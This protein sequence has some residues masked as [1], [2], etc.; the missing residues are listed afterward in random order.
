MA[1][2]DESLSGKGIASYLHSKMDCSGSAYQCSDDAMAS[3]HCWG[4]Q[5]HATTSPTCSCAC[6]G[7]SECENHQ[8]GAHP[9]NC[10]ALNRSFSYLVWPL[11]LYER[12]C[13]LSFARWRFAEG[14]RRYGSPQPISP[15]LSWSGAKVRVTCLVSVDWTFYF[16]ESPTWLCYLSVD[17]P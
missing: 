6:W 4:A 9:R 12:P 7:R 14:R 16:S 17:S 10:W 11:S 13:L 3:R 15:S 8:V 2:L 1:S 5:P